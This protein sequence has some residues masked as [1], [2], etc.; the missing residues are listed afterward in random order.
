M[1]KNIKVK[2]ICKDIV[3]ILLI[4]IFL[5]FSFEGFSSFILFFSKLQKARIVAERLHTEYDS[6]LGWINKRNFY[7]QDMYGP[8]MYLRINSQR[9]RNNRDFDIEIPNGK[10]RWICSGDS[11]T[12]GYGV[13]NDHTWSSLLSSIVPDIETINM[14]QGGYGLDQSYLWYMR[15]GVQLQH[16][17]LVLAFITEDIPR[18][19]VNQFLSYPKPRLYVQNGK[20]IKQN[21]PVP[22][23]GFLVKYLPRYEPLIA[24]L[25]IMQ[26]TGTLLEKL[27]GNASEIESVLAPQ[28]II[29]LTLSIFSTLYSF[30]KKFDRTVLLIHLPMEKEYKYSPKLDALRTFLHLQAKK[31]G[32][33]YF[34]LIEDFR[35]L[36]SASI[37]ELFIQK[38]LPDFIDSRGHYTEKGNRYIAGLIVE[39]IASNSSIANL[40]STLK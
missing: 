29:E 17:V 13:D 27:K 14:G 39:K 23:P 33:F 15:D 10:R 12:F 38:D 25:S 2:S 24:Q 28:E 37:P 31:N 4:T 30:N 36:N 26:L 35:N 7:I 16:D 5:F 20:I 19:A 9:F 6:L 18:M 40:V 11:F 21:V 32:W 22:R 1:K 8:N 3:V 34:D